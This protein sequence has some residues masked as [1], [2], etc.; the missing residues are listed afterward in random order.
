MEAVRT[1][2][3]SGQE[4]RAGRAAVRPAWKGS[5]AAC[6][7]GTRSITL[8]SACN[9]ISDELQIICLH[10]KLTFKALQRTF[11]VQCE[12]QFACCCSCSFG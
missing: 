7:E 4:G 9:M 2:C 11:T 8:A 6:G 10:N 12:A 5:G 3:W 1:R